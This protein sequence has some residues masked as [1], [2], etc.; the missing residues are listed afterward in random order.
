MNHL[1]DGWA[2]TDATFTEWRAAVDRRLEDVYAI[3]IDDAGIDDALLRSHWEEKEA[4]FEFVS[5]F[6]NKY[7]LDPSQMFGHLSG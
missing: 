3:S 6:G 2:W 1:E 4:P 7:D 5:W